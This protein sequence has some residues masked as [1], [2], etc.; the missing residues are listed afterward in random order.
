MTRRMGRK[1]NS[2]DD[3]SVKMNAMEDLD[4]MPTHIHGMDASMRIMMIIGDQ[5]RNEMTC[6]G[7]IYRPSIVKDEQFFPLVKPEPG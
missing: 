5:M 3:I 6:M 2:I 1:T 7:G 4:P